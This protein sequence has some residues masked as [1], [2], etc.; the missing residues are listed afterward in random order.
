MSD[1]VFT[2]KAIKPQRLQVERIRQSVLRALEQE[3]KEQQK[4]LNET[5]ATWTGDKPTF[6]SITDLSGGDASVLSGPGGNTMGVK[7]W[8]WLNEGTSVRRAVM[9]KNWRSKTTPGSFR[10]G[11]GS[12]RVVFISRRISRPGIKARGWTQKLTN[13]R[14]QPFT[15]RMIQA[16]RQAGSEAF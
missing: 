14:R 2:I 1:T 4:T 7:K 11:G 13:Q 16:M 15:N 6:D 3:A 5:T 12:G 10:S 8:N 9:S